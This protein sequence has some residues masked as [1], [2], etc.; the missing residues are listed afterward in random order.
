MEQNLVDVD[1][2][3]ADQDSIVTSIDDISSK[4]PFLISI[5]DDEKK[6]LPKPGEVFSPFIDEAAKLVYAHPE[7]MSGTFDIAGYKRDLN[8]RDSLRLISGKL[9]IL[10]KGIEDT[11][12]AVDSDLYVSSLD[13]YFESKPKVTK[14]AGLS[15]FVD[16]M[17]P[18]FKRNRVVASAPAQT[19][20]K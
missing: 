4:L 16:K 8:L 11:L 10:K 15:V 14:V 1:L 13:V 5:T 17:R 19:P 2:P 7:I 18:Y 12:T 20:A 3:Q 6:Q 9:D